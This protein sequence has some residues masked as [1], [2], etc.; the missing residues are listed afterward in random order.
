MLYK[1]EQDSCAAQSVECIQEN[2]S[3]YATS[4]ESMTHDEPVRLSF[5]AQ[6]DPGWLAATA[7]AEH[8]MPPIF[9]SASLLVTASFAKRDLLSVKDTSR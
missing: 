3:L 8:Q 1:P 5:T 4:P 9:R 6:A 2:R 7:F